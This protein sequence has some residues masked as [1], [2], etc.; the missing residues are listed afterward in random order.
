MLAECRPP[1]GDSSRVDAHHLHHGLTG[2]VF[3]SRPS[4]PSLDQHLVV[5]LLLGT[6]IILYTV[7]DTLAFQVT[8]NYHKIL[9]MLQI[10]FSEDLPLLLGPYVDILVLLVLIDGVVDEAVLIE[11]ALPSSPLLQ[12]YGGNDGVRSHLLVLILG[13]QKVA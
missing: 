2:R 6:I 7:A 5:L 13:V 9:G 3:V 1:G 8:R 12:Q 4:D 11:V 10:L